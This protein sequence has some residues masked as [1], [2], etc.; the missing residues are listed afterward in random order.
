LQDEDLQEQ[1]QL[2][3]QQC[4]N[5]VGDTDA[6]QYFIFTLINGGTEYSVS[7]GPDKNIRQLSIPGTYNGLPV[8]AI[9]DSAFYNCENIREITVPTGVVNIGVSAFARCTN[10]SQVKFENDRSQLKIIGNIAFGFCENLKTFTF[11]A[12]VTSI[13][14][15][16]FYGC[17]NLKSIIFAESSKLEIID[18]A[19]FA[20]CVN[21]TNLLLPASVKCIGTKAFYKTSNENPPIASD[22]I[23]IGRWS[24][25]EFTEDG[26]A[27]TVHYIFYADNKLYVFCG[28]L[29]YTGG[30]YTVNGN[31]ISFLRFGLSINEITSAIYLGQG[32]PLQGTFEI[33]NNTLTIIAED[34]Q[35]VFERFK[36]FGLWQNTDANAIVT[37]KLTGDNTFN[38]IVMY[39]DE[40]PTVVYNGTFQ[41]SLSSNMRLMVGGKLVGVIRF[42]AQDT[43]LVQLPFDLDESV[44]PILRGSIILTRT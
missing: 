36:Y 32:N 37:L 3:P 2:Q 14:K 33:V 21:L 22:D 34:V 23:I 18:A 30:A 1:E 31:K 38:L 16:A 5:N 4:E 44:D 29:T 27:A 42:R 43:L 19:A 35:M 13:G 6:E 28:G 25:Q 26:I 11:P 7:S 9:G 17:K 8:T 39:R 12:S 10:L 20:G 15:A 40:R 41:H 24:T